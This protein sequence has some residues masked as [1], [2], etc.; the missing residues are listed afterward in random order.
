MIWKKD[1][2]RL[3]LALGMLGPILGLAL[4]WQ[5]KFNEMP[6]AEFLELF[7]SNN[8]LITSIGS[9]SLLTNAVLF[10]IYINTERD[11]TAKGIFISTVIYGIG[12]LI[13]K[14]FN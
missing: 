11:E 3:G 2:L 5:F 10:T 14:I 8:R 4:I 9:L 1:N 12:I 6:F 13:L 7:M